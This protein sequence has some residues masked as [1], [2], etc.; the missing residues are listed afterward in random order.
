MISL[1]HNLTVDDLIVV[2]LIQKIEQ[3]YIPEVTEQEFMD[4][5]QYFTTKKKV[6]DV[7]WDYPKLINRFLERKNQSDWSNGPHME[8]T[9][10]GI[11]KANNKLS[12]YD[13][14][15]INTYCMSI[16]EKKEIS[17]YVTEYLKKLPKRSFDMEVIKDTPILEICKLSSALIMEA[18]WKF[19]I[20]KQVECGCWPKQ[21]NDIF[22]YLLEDD[23]A[24][25]IEL[26]S[27]KKDLLEFYKDFAQKNSFLLIDNPQLHISNLKN[28]YL[29]YS[30]YQLLLGED[31]DNLLRQFCDQVF[32]KV[33]DINYESSTMHIYKKKLVSKEINFSNNIHA[34]KL[35]KALEK[36][37]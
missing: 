14:S 6:D 36:H 10:K 19:K 21:C 4:F 34:K 16:V 33:I 9:D 24:L 11:L 2:Y 18:I 17:N 23:L 7:L 30:N 20:Q 26:T 25:K 29:P 8:F 22:K 13:R 31:K 5:L 27:I 12:Y 3:G 32:T 37:N 35:V 15:V 28:I 1:T